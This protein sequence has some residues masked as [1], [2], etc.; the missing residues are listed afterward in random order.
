M[1]HDLLEY[2]QSFNISVERRLLKGGGVIF[3]LQLMVPE[4]QHKVP[5]T[6]LQRLN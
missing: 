6:K 2:F 5:G 1:T 4:K 3:L